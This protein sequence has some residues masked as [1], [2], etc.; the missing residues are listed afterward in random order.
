MAIPKFKSLAEAYAV[1]KQLEVTGD[2]NKA[3]AG[4]TTVAL[5]ASAMIKIIEEVDELKKKSST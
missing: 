3:A 5:L 4:M 1:L 2:D